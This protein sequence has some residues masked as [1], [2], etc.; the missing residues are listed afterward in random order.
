MVCAMIALS[1][2]IQICVEGAIA[3]SAEVLVIHG[4]IGHIETFINIQ[5]ISRLLVS[6]FLP[7]KSERS[8][9]AVS[10]INSIIKAKS[11][12]TTP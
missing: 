12:G 11:V 1:S 6:L 8:D 7:A 4:I 5:A 10:E 9:T 3:I 2:S